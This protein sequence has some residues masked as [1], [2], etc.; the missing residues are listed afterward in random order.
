MNLRCP[1]LHYLCGML[2]SGN[3]WVHLYAYADEKWA[4]RVDPSEIP[5][6]KK[7]LIQDLFGLV[8]SPHIRQ[9]AL[10]FS[11]SELLRWMKAVKR[12][13]SG[14]PLQYV[15]GK[16][17]F[18]GLTLEVNPQVLIPR[19]ETEELVCLVS[20][21]FSASGDFRVLDVCT[22]S[23]CIALGIQS[24]R[25]KWTVEGMDISPGAVQ[26]AARNAVATE[27]PVSF[28]EAD[29]F[30]DDFFSGKTWDVWISNPPYI[31]KAEVAE[32]SPSVLDYEPHLALFA[33]TEDPLRFY[34]RLAELAP[35][36]LRGGGGVFM[37]INPGYARE[38][39]TLFTDVQ[40]KAEIHRDFSGKE[41][42]VAAFR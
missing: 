30:S 5:A 2:P 7:A 31:T 33:G 39:A 34:N 10:R 26:T 9:D 1:A 18:L 16:A 24:R 25:P 13:A 42:F 32:M 8:V 4:G 27:L 20:D 21:S 14:E 17:P 3:T 41:R 38:V 35:S 12:V 15:T 22:G 11:E 6:M 37:E 23:G 29:V 28:Y 36:H 19:P 40:M